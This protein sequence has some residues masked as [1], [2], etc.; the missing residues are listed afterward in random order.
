[1]LPQNKKQTRISENQSPVTS[2]SSDLEENTLVKRIIRKNKSQSSSSTCPVVITEKCLRVPGTG[3]WSRLYKDI[4]QDFTR[5]NF[6]R[7]NVPYDAR[8]Y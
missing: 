4:T 2:Y 7:A 8:T 3:Y 5:A 6:T 1:M